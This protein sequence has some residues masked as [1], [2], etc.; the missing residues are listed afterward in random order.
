MTY[1]TVRWPSRTPGVRYGQV[2]HD[3]RKARGRL[4]HARTQLG[5]GRDT[6]TGRAAPKTT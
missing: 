1:I 3:A 6:V 4:G 5:M 2:R